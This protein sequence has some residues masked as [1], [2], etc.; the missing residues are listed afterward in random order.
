MVKPYCTTLDKSIEGTANS[1]YRVQADG[2]NV[3]C[4]QSF[5]GRQRVIIGTCSTLGTLTQ[6]GF[7]MGH[8]T[9]IIVDE[10]AQVTAPEIMMALTF[11]DKVN[12]QIILAGKP[13][14]LGPVVTSHYAKEL[15]MRDFC[16][17][18]LL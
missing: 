4:G 15:G 6:M 12:G 8:F 17:C 11:T 2:V 1:N 9:H 14:Q 13:L 5:I 18:R 10:A 3:C 16:L 7:P